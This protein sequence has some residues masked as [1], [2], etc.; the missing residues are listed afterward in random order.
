[1]GA[2]AVAVTREKPLETKRMNRASQVT[3]VEDLVV[4]QEK[5]GSH[6]RSLQG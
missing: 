3:A 1:L 5:E 2:V 4:A 6:K